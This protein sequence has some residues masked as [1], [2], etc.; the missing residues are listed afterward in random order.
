MERIVQSY[1]DNPR[2]AQLWRLLCLLAASLVLAGL[3]SA[4]DPR[5]GY[6]DMKRLFD[7]APQ[8]VSA[9]QALDDEFSPRNQLLLTDEARLQRLENEL[10]SSG[11][12]DDE[13]RF[14]TERE[15]R[16]LR[17]YIEQIGRAP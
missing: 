10:P 7:A 5:I 17:R 13:Q 15:I 11:D 12:L 8:V 1:S 3:A 14:E 6:V 4:Q 16:N 9:R 2:A